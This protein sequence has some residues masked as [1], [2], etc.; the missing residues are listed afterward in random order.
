MS[1]GQPP[2]REVAQRAFAREFNA[3]TYTFREDDDERA[4]I[5]ALLPTGAKANHVFIVGKLTKTEDAGNDNEY[6]Q[7][8]IVDPMG[9]VFVY[10]GQYQPEAASMLRETEPPAFVAVVGK[11]RVPTKPTTEL[12]TFHSAL[13]IWPSSTPT[14]LIDG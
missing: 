14:L 5:Y 12:S 7:E 10:A 1:Q 2:M 6:W 13:S 9:T 3:A 4:P 11:P 8:Q